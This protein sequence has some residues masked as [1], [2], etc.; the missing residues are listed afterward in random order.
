M[1]HPPAAAGVCAETPALT[2]FHGSL[3]GNGFVRARRAPRGPSNFG[4]PIVATMFQK[5]ACGE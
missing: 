3:V 1:A 4:Q 5:R 2:S